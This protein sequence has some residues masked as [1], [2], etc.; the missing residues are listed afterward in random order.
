MGYSGYDIV[1]GHSTSIGFDITEHN[2]LSEPYSECRHAESLKLE[3]DVPYSYVECRNMCVHKI[4]HAKMWIAGQP[5]M[6]QDKEAQTPTVD[7][8]D[9]SMKH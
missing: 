6:L 5:D 4:V 2:R 7:M 1:P 9:S 8:T 3:G